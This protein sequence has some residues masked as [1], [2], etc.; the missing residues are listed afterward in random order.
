MPAAGRRGT[1]PPRRRLNRSAPHTLGTRFHTERQPPE[2]PCRPRPFAVSRADPA[3]LPQHLFA[4]VSR[5][6]RNPPA[7]GL[8][9]LP[10]FTGSAHGHRSPHRWR[11]EVFCIPILLIGIKHPKHTALHELAPIVIQACQL[12]GQIAPLRLEISW[13]VHPNFVV[14]L[15]YKADHHCF[16]WSFTVDAVASTIEVGIQ[17][18]QPQRKVAP[19]VQPATKHSARQQRHRRSKAR[20][21]LSP[22]TSHS[23]VPRYIHRQPTPFIGHHP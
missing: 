22:S 18:R 10:L 1:H 15:L 8:A 12:V 11:C 2:P 19:V 14:R 13:H 5:T 20:I 6:D 3:G 9:R 4:L 7:I 23:K 21:G 16:P 17:V